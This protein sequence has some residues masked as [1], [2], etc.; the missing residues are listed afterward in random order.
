MD[1]ELAM[2]K[3]L[4]ITGGSRGIGAATARLASQRGY[5]VAINYA[6]NLA[7]AEEVASAVRAAGRRAMTIKGDVGDPTAIR[8]IFSAVD[9]ELGRLDAFLNNAG[10]LWPHARFVDIST[11]QLQRTLAINLTGAFIAAQ[12]AAKRM[13]TK[14]GGGGGVITNMSPMAAKLGGAFECTDYGAS[15]GGLET[16]TIGM[17]KELAGEGVRVNTVRPGLIDTDIHASAGEPGRVER[18]MGTVP[19][20]RA[21]QASDVAEAALWLMSDAAAYLTGVTI[22]VAGGRGI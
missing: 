2:A 17:A 19:L 5:D 21:G 20:G 3:I 10:I 11:D 22:D 4:L 16:L 14:R 6:T 15:K 18:L 7:A 13:S 12:E 8:S 9:R 1:V